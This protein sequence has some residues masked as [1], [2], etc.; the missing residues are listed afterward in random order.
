MIFQTCLD[1]SNYELRIAN[2]E[3]IAIRHSAF[4]IRH[5]AFA[6]H[7]IPS[8]PPQLEAIFD[9]AE[10]RYLKP[11]ELQLLSQYVDSLPV[12]LSAYRTLRDRELEVM[13]LVAD[14]LQAQLPNEKLRIWSVPSK[15]LC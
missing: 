5:S 13:Q 15:T 6:I 12:R 11:N 8:M 1:K 2:Y 9:D 10:S 7:S 4:A 3:L 14:Q